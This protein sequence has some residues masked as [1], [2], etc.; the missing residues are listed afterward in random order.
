MDTVRWAFQV[1]GDQLVALADAG[2]EA[3]VLDVL[4]AMSNPR[5]FNIAPGGD[6]SRVEGM[7]R[8]RGV[9]SSLGYTPYFGR[10]WSRMSAF[11]F[12]YSP[13][14]YLYSPFSYQ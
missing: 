3:D 4:V 14:G 11:G 5:H 6:P 9:V 13:W 10:R 1:N 8:P 7:A 12:Y 2:V